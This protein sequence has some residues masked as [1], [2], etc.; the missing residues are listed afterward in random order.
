M[1]YYSAIKKNK[2]IL[3]FATTWKD[4]EG[5]RLNEISHTEEDK[6]CMISL[7]CGFLK[8]KKKKRKEKKQKYPH[9]THR[10]R[11]DQICDY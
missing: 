7:I 5:I 10:K 1:E 9:Q 4:L 11:G 3:L 2:E 8:K 6:Y